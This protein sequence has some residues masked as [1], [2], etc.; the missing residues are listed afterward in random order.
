MSLGRDYVADQAEILE[1][2]YEEIAK[3]AKAKIWTTKDGRKKHV[4]TMTTQH[5]KNTLAWIERNDPIDIMMPWVN[6][7]IEELRRRGEEE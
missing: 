2:Q 6:V 5:I 4:K 1:L 7:F 3:R